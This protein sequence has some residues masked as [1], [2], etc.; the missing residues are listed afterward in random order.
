MRVI[1]GMD[2]DPATRASVSDLQPVEKPT[3]APTYT[4]QRDGGRPEGAS[5]SYPNADKVPS[6]GCFANTGEADFAFLL[7]AFL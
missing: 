1:L 6:Y 3:A 4:W 2:G 7:R 5:A